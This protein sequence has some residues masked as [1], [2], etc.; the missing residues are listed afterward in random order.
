[1]FSP[2]L[3]FFFFSFFFQLEFHVLFSSSNGCLTNIRTNQTKAE[4]L[5]GIGTA[6]IHQ[7]EER[8]KDEPK[9]INDKNMNPH[10]T[11]NGMRKNPP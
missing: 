6:H 7:R 9:T 1:V 4:T 8:E 3:A 2:V 10:R 11:K 5:A